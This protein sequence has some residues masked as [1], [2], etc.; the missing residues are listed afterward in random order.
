ME[1]VEYFPNSIVL[2]A[3]QFPNAVVPTVVTLLRSTTLSFAA[4][5]P[6]VVREEQ[7]SKA[8][9][10]IV[11]TVAGRTIFFSPIQFLNS[12]FGTTLISAPVEKVT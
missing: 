11:V 2:I 12:P 6:N 1:R 10:S 5:I 8:F 3:E 7:F 4:P 9:A